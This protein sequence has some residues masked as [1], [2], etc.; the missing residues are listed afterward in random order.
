VEEEN[1]ADI[2]AESSRRQFMIRATGILTFLSS[3]IVV[4]P[5][6]GSVIGPAFRR[7]K[8][9]WI[10]VA[11]IRDLPA[12]EPLSLKVADVEVDAYL[13]QSVIRHLWVI[14]HSDAK[15]TVLSPTCTHLGCQYNWNP[16]SGHFECPC[17]GSIYAPD[18]KVLGG[19]APR[20][21]DTLATRIDKGRLSVAWQQFRSGIAEKI[22][23]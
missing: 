20:S 19:P 11:D 3:L 21:L 4:V 9:S 17:H 13:R 2:D 8:S 7:T 23:V 22:P 12:G 6:A 18:G 10:M 1:S 14:K 16:A 15:V 5:L